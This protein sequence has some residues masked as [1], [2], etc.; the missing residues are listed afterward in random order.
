M[1]LSQP[2]I[3]SLISSVASSSDPI[4]KD[5]FDQ[6]AKSLRRGVGSVFAD[7]SFT[8]LHA[9]LDANVS[10]FA[11]YKAY[12]ATQ[13]IRQA[14]SG[15]GDIEDGRTEV[16]KF[17]R[18]LAAEYNTAVARSRTAK[19]W[20]EWDSSEERSLFPNI[21]W[22]PSR[23]ATLREQHIPFYNRVWAKDDPFWNHNQPGTLWNCKC[24]WQQTDEPVTSNNPVRNVS[25][26]G[27][28]GNPAKTGQIFSDKASY[29]TKAP[30][31]ADSE[32]KK[33][34]R[35]YARNEALSSNRK[36]PF[37]CQIGD[38]TIMMDLSVK[39]PIKHFSQDMYGSELFWIKNNILIDQSILKNARFIGYDEVDLGHNTNPRTLS[40]KKRL[41]YYYYYKLDIGGKDI[42]IHFCHYKDTGNIS[43][44]TATDQPPKKMIAP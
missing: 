2:S 39:T 8:D 23:S 24:D 43:L 12:V 18:W 19:Q 33:L 5:L 21:M 44:Y 4:S 20:S 35:D 16:N 6:Y 26:Q 31:D 37:P 10:R 13:R 42:Y 40:F 15:N 28:E 1:L 32:T 38:D 30:S 25:S 17:N 3:D 41:D 7:G 9:Q 36:K 11:A 27:L 14:V 29:F 34:W 22:L